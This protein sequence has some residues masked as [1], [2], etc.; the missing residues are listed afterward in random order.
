VPRFGGLRFARD[1]RRLMD[2]WVRSMLFRVSGLDAAEITS[3]VVAECRNGGDFLRLV[4]ESVARNQNVERWADCTPHHL[5][6]MEEIKRQIPD[7]IF[8]HIIRDGRDVALSYLRQGWAH[9]LP[10]DRG[11][12][13]A[14]AALYWKWIVGRGRAAG[15]TLGRDYQEVRFEDLVANPQQV[16]ARLGQFIDHNLDYDKIQQAGIGAVS[17]PNS[18][19]ELDPTAEFDP[20]GRWKTKMSGRDLEHFEALAGDRLRELGYPL[21][22]SPASRSAFRDVR[23]RSTYRS[24]SEIKQWLKTS[25]PL[26]RLVRLNRIELEARPQN[27]GASSRSN[28]SADHVA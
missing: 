23:L 5:L 8:I 4:M 7:A 26:G 14:V 13:M 9:P 10:W 12:E 15:K 27:S 20:V 1:R 16:L 6:S 3:K 17:E 25:T 22:S 28:D 21:A 19:F 18:S 2:A 24:L 11:E